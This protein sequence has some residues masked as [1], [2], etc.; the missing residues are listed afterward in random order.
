[1]TEHWAKVLDPVDNKSVL[2]L[3][4][5]KHSIADTLER[6]GG[7]RIIGRAEMAT[8][9]WWATATDMTLT[10]MTISSFTIQRARH[11]YGDGVFVFGIQL[12]AL[13]EEPGFMFLPSAEYIR[14]SMRPKGDPVAMGISFEVGTPRDRSAAVWEEVGS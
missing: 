13:S 2:G 8:A 12:E 1:M 14:R 3:I 11:R 4:G 10:D 6:R 9:Q 7:H 5:M